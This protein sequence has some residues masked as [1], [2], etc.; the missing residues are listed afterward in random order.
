MITNKIA[1]DTNI[2]IYCHE[3]N[4]RRLTRGFVGGIV[5][6]DGLFSAISHKKI[7]L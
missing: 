5:S 2:L 1:L 3:K 4:S 7:E 6:G